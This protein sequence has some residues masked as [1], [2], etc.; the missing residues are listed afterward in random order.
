MSAKTNLLDVIPCHKEHIITEHDG[1]LVII[2]FPRFKSAWVRKYL[3]PKGISPYI[4]VRLEEHGSA[5]WNLIDGKRNVREIID[6]LSEHF[7]DE[8]NYASRITIYLSQL[9]KDGFI[10]Y[11]IG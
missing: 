6:L 1:E 11:L 4:R 10:K 2:A 5:V 3:L 8:D 7:N 9:R